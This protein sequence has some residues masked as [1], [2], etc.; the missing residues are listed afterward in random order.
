MKISDWICPWCNKHHL[1]Y[2]E[3]RVGSSYGIKLCCTDPTEH[4]CPDTTG[5]C[6]TEEQ[7]DFYAAELCGIDFK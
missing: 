5:I 3:A 6:D 1:H 7:C 4:S 2:V